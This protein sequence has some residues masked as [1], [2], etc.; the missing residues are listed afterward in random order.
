MEASTHQ[1][2]RSLPQCSHLDG[3]RARLDAAASL[4]VQTAAQ[5]VQAPCASC[6]SQWNRPLAGA[7]AASQSHSSTEDRQ[8]SG[9]RC[10]SSSHAGPEGGHAALALAGLWRG[11][12]HAAAVHPA[13]GVPPAR[14][15]APAAALHLVA[16]WRPTRRKVAAVL[17]GCVHV[18]QS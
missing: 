12:G 17:H 7:A 15:A 4:Q 3:P 2:G 10:S 6:S 13:L 9:A 1:C 16:P 14:V 11:P 18:V 5:Q 8:H